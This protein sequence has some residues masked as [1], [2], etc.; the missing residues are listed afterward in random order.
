MLAILYI[1]E[2][3]VAGLE[4]GGNLPVRPRTRVTLTSLTATFEESMLMEE[5]L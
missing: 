1:L 5:D 4:R 2:V 3:F